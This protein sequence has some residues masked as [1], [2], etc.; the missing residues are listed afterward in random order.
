MLPIT[1]YDRELQFRSAT[2][3]LLDQNPWISI[4]K[5]PNWK[6]LLNPLNENIQQVLI[7]S[8]KYL[9][10]G[11]HLLTVLPNGST[12]YCNL[13]NGAWFDMGKSEKAVK[14][15]IVLMVDFSR[16][17]SDT[18]FGGQISVLDV[19]VY[20]DINLVDFE[21]KDRYNIVKVLHNA[22]WLSCRF[23]F[24]F[25]IEPTEIKPFAFYAYY[26]K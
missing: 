10:W 1:L 2:N 6:P 8:E 16:E 25:A 24:R 15:A 20:D 5:V 17:F 4:P 14:G 18:L 9:N 12:A 22:L 26:L 11:P 21:V 3:I 7:V 13:E 23:T 19:L